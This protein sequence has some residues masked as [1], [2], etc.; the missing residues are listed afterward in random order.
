M[1][2]CKS[3]IYSSLSLLETKFEENCEICKNENNYFEAITKNMIEIRYFSAFYFYFCK[4][5]N[6]I[7]A[8]ISVPNAIK[9]K[10]ITFNDDNEYLAKYYK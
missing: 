5:I 9:F 2:L 7:L 8:S 6:E 3:I 10:D 1:S 4:S